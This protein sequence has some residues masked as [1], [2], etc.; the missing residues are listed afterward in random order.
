MNFLFIRILAR[1]ASPT[2]RSG[3]GQLVV[4]MRPHPQRVC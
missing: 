4:T 1:R 3:I 2:R